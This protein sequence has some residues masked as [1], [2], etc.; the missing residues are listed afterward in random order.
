MLVLALPHLT[1]AAT[2]HSQGEEGGASVSI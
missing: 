2:D 1:G